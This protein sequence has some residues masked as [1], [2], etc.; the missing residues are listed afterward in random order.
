VPQSTSG[1]ASAL[2]PT[3]PSSVTERPARTWRD[4]TLLL[5][6]ACLWSSSYPLTKIGLGSIPPITFIAARSFVAAMTVPAERL[7][8]TRAR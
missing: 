7:K 5:T 4:Y 2:A 6:L 1:R 3:H 8:R